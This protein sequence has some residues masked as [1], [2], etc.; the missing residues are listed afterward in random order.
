METKTKTRKLKF[1]FRPMSKG[2]GKLT[3]RELW[4][5]FLNQGGFGEA[6]RHDGQRAK[7]TQMAD[8]TLKA[9]FADG[10]VID[11]RKEH[12]QAKF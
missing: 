7:V 9:E 1:T 10:L 4:D 11:V 8:N 3:L 6:K 12:F 5:E 2:K